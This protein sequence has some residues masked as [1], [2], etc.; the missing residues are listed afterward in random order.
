VSAAVPR[1][2]SPPDMDRPSGRWVGGLIGHPKVA[3]ASV[4]RNGAT[5]P[6]LAS[7]HPI[8]DAHRATPHP[9]SRPQHSPTARRPPARHLAV[10]LR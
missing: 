10:P 9:R 7:K 4:A 8:P 2:V 3:A 1:L 5:P 6:P